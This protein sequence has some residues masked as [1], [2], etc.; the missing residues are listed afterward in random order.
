MKKILVTW[1]FTEISENALEYAIRIAKAVNNEIILLHIVKK[2]EEE[3]KALEKLQPV[4]EMVFQKYNIKPEIIAIEGSIFSTIGDFTADEE[5]HINL[6]VMG[7]H[8]IRGMQKLTG[9]WAL[10]VI[11]SSKAPFIVVQDVPPQKEKFSDIVFPI[12][13]KTENKEKLLWAIY[14]AKFFE[15]KIHVFKPLETDKYYLKKIN[16]NLSFALK[17]FRK[18]AVDYEI[19]TAEKSGHFAEETLKFG[20][21]INADLILIMTTK[22][23][24]FSDYVF[25]AQEQYIIANAAK[26]PVMCINPRTD[27]T[28]VSYVIGG[29][30]G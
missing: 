27:L 15:S 28:T 21:K 14:L 23:I 10:K 2:K 13:F 25:G 6:V 8:G 16:A 12:N 5:N 29:F 4:A 26:I 3:D 9:S 18:K 30:G 1:D 17:Y 7:T 11:A 24:G 19:H 22:G 20:K